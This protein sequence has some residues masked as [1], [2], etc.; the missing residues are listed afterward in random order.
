MCYLFCQLCS[1]QPYIPS[2]PIFYLFLSVALLIILLN[3]FHCCSRQNSQGSETYL[4][5]GRQNR[6]GTLRYQDFITLPICMHFSLLTSLAYIQWQIMALQSQLNCQHNQLTVVSTRLRIAGRHY[7]CSLLLIHLNTLHFL[8][9]HEVQK[10]L[11]EKIV[12]GYMVYCQLCA[13]VMS[14]E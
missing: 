9:Q 8:L 3:F 7:L 14:R 2:F 4:D 5:D 1:C 12:I 13:V 6:S 11:N 10:I